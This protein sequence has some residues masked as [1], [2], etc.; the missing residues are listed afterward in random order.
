MAG[1]NPYELHSFRE[2]R[3]V[4]GQAYIVCRPCRRFVGVGAWLDGLDTRLVT[5]SCTVCGGIGE[6]TVEDPAREGLQH[7]LRPNPPRHPEVAA[8]LRHIQQ[9][10]NPFG[11]RLTVVRELL[12]QSERTKFVPEPQYRLRPMPFATFGDL[13]GLGLMLEV[14]CSTCKSSRPVMVGASWAGLP[15]GRGRFTCGAARFGRGVCGG[16]GHPHIVP[17][18]PAEPSLAFVSLNCPRCVP[19]WSVSPVHLDRLP[20][21]SSPI[22]MASERYRCPACGGQVRATFHGIARRQREG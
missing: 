12:P 7:D 4:M 6:L 17:L 1:P 3:G 22:D 16:L 5:F 2:L 21:N 15:F 10:A 13:S 11:R 19:S 20:W 18:Q 14:W 9:L 8:R